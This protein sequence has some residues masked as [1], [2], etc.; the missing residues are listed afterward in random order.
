M[1]PVVAKKQIADYPAQLQKK[2]GEYR[3][4]N[5]IFIKCVSFAFDFEDV[6]KLLKRMNKTGGL[7]SYDPELLGQYFEKGDVYVEGD[8]HPLDDRTFIMQNNFDN[9]CGPIGSWVSIRGDDDLAMQCYTEK[10]RAL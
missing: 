7:L 1:H 2:I 3:C 8:T 9:G 10:E 5:H 6:R 4:T